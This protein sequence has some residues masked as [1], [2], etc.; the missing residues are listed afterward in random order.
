MTNKLG[1]IKIAIDF[2]GT[3][4]YSRDY[5]D[6]EYLKLNAIF[7]AY[8]IPY[9]TVRQAYKDVRDRGF[10]PNRFVTTLHDAGYDFSTD[11]ALGAIQRWIGE[12]LVIYDDAK[13]A[14]P[15]WMNKGI[16]VIIV[17]T[18]EADWQVQKITA[19]NINPS[20]VIVT[21]SD[22]EK[23]F[24]IKKLAE[25]SKIIAIDDKATM[26]DML[27]DIDSDGELFVTTRILRQESKYIT[28]KPRH[29]HISV[30]SLLDSRIDEIL[31]F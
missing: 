26:L 20:E 18:G 1:V 5:K 28:Q 2:D 23:M 22:E 24:V 19:L 4:A 12:N 16:N 7:E 8:G 14:L 3:I 25:S 17:T 21:S 31:G 27:R 6:G 10:S 29:D 9:A 13:K 30:I 15:I 11:D